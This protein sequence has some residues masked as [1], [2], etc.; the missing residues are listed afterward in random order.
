MIDT[1]IIEYLPSILKGAF[2][3]FII[4]LLSA[5]IG[6]IFGTILA[7]IQNYGNYYIKLL[8]NLYLVTIRGTP[9]L[10]QITFLYIL[11]GNLFGAFTTAIIAIGLNSA[12]YVSQII[13]SGINSVSIGQIEAA[14]TLGISNYFI[15]KSIILPQALVVILPSLGNELITLIKDT[16]LAY[17]I[18]VMEL[19]QTARVVI[20][21][22]Y[23]PIPIYIIISLIYLSMTALVSLFINKLEKKLNYAKD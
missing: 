17:V 23:D 9:M 3:S 5:C 21:R 6:A 22:T 20:S 8:I 4:A 16:S 2:I 13:K 14:K 18:G 12:A 7:I 10:I 15:V 19:F 1:V 11:I